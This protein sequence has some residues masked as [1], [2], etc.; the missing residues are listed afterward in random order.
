LADVAVTAAGVGLTG[1]LLTDAAA[2]GAVAVGGAAV[3]AAT[4]PDEAGEAARFVGGSVANVTQAYSELAALQAELA[5]LEQQKKAQAAVD[6]FVEDVS[7]IPGNV[8]ST[9][10]KTVTETVD[11]VKAAP[12]KAIDTISSDIQSKLESTQAAAKAELDA[13]KKKLEELN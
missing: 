2:L 12:G 4:R 1:E 13:A 10:T 9:V 7:A 6:S 5:L 3:Y 11:T 8:Q